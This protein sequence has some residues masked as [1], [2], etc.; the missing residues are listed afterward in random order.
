MYLEISGFTFQQASDR[1]GA[2][3]INLVGQFWHSFIHENRFQNS[4]AGIRLTYSASVIIHDNLFE[5]GEFGGSGITIVDSFLNIKVIENTFLN[6]RKYLGSVAGIG[7]YASRGRFSKGSDIILAN[8]NLRNISGYGIIVYDSVGVKIRGNTVESALIGIMVYDFSE[9]VS[10]E[11]NWV[12]GQLAH[13]I[14]ISYSSAVINGNLIEENQGHGIEIWKGEMERAPAVEL[15]QN[16]IFRNMQFGIWSERV[17]YV[18][19]CRYN[20]LKEN[21]AGDYATGPITEP[22]PSPE[23]KQKCEGK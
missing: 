22:Q 17:E 20:Q 14:S 16:Q 15:L 2:V 18:T 5:G 1:G 13:G 6:L 12:R 11:N 3:G 7:I 21:K 8:N 19:A 23:L 9:A 4:I 10:I